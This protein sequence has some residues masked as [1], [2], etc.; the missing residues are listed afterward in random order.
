VGVANSSKTSGRPAVSPQVKL[1]VSLP[2]A[3]SLTSLRS[4][5]HP[6][7]TPS[8]KAISLPANFRQIPEMAHLPQSR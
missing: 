1:L 8:R 2:S 6:E 3:R 7:P 4:R 5:P